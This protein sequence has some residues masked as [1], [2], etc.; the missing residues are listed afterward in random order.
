MDSRAVLMAL[1]AA[2]A[3]GIVAAQAVSDSRPGPSTPVTVVNGTINPVP[4][5]GTVTGT[6]SGT[7]EV[8]DGKVT[9]TSDDNTD[10]LLDTVIELTSTARVATIAIDV[11]RYK[12]VRIVALMGGCVNCNTA[13]F[14]IESDF[15][16][17]DS[18]NVPYT[19]GDAF[20]FS[21]TYFTRVLEVP[22]EKLQLAGAMA[23]S[24]TSS[25]WVV[26]V[27]GR[28]N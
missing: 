2:G 16:P 19:T 7:V 9:T 12:S 24:G 15:Y 18:F 20:N 27:Y 4:V 22:G 14:R 1:A 5:T 23:N 13:R 25:Y 28:R 3:S 21:N 26:R 11:S 10:L 8:T 17:L 6:V